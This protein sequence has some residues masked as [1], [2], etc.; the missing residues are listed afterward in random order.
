MD[1]L[2][3]PNLQAFGASIV[4]KIMEGVTDYLANVVDTI[5]AHPGLQAL[6]NYLDL[7]PAEALSSFSDIAEAAGNM[8]S[9]D[10]WD[11]TEVGNQIA[12]LTSHLNELRAASENAES[13]LGDLA[14]A[15]IDLGSIFSGNLLGS[16]DLSNLGSIATAISSITGAIGS[17][18]GGGSILSNLFGGL[19][20]GALDSI[21]GL[22]SENGGVSNLLG[23]LFG[24]SGITDMLNNSDFL[25]PTIT[26]VIDTS[27]VSLGIDSITDMFN[28]AN[29]DQF[30]IDAGNSML[31]R[32]AAEGDAANSGGVSYNFT[33]INNSP[34][35]LSPI[36][37]YRDTN[38]LFRG[39]INT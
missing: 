28:N 32:E 22:I 30:A 19:G 29:V 9:G 6:L 3:F 7:D 31:I 25:S 12:A 1:D 20:S 2:G 16:F 17:N 8:A 5:A 26:P 37:I 33:Q 14:S 10:T 15:P 4:L 24:T 39:V 13:S 38:N 21:S 23:G 27:E 35:A 18:S 34:E 11:S 36:Q